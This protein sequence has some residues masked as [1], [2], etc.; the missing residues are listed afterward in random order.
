MDGVKG[1]L[2][3]KSVLIGV[4]ATAVVALGLGLGLGLGLRPKA[5]TAAK[6]CK[7][8]Y[9]VKMAQLNESYYELDGFE[10]H[11]EASHAHWEHAG[12]HYLAC[13]D[14][15]NI[16][17]MIGTPG[18]EIS[19]FIIGI[20]AKLASRKDLDLTTSNDKLDLVMLEEM[21]NYI[22]ENNSPERPFFYHTGQ[23]YLNNAL[24]IMRQTSFPYVRPITNLTLWLDA[25]SDASAQ[26]CSHLRYMLLEPTIYKVPYGITRSAIKTVYKLQWEAK[27]APKILIHNYQFKM[28]PKG[29][30]VV[31]PNKDVAMPEECAEMQP[32]LT[33]TIYPETLKQKSAFIYHQHY[34]EEFR[35]K[36]LAPYFMKTNTE[37]AAKAM[38]EL[39]DKQ[40]D[41]TIE[42]IAYGLPIAVM[43]Y[44]ATLVEASAAGADSHGAASGAAASGGH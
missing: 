3:K 20:S 17:G 28:K 13:V 9:H 30:L 39:A 8:D 7:F 24:T 26:G 27:Y 2:A 21:R 25:L 32:L 15:R 35:T 43:E 4:G 41:R 40:L 14:P 31:A 12:H 16:D 19:E 38:I 10:Y 23:D 22:N 6:E 37:S 29:I 1:L 5:S 44:E 34:I 11:I 42:H 33:P 18:G 36:V